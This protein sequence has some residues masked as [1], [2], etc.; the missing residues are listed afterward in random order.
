MTGQD[1]KR[2]RRR[3]S[4]LDEPFRPPLFDGFAPAALQFFRDLADNQ[5][6]GWMA[7]NKNIYERDAG[8]PAR[9]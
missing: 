1:D 2:G 4:G 6:R 3:A 5:D 7:R 8:W 9:P